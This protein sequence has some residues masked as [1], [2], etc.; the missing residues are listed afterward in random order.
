MIAFGYLVSVVVV[1]IGV[2]FYTL[3]LNSVS[4]ATSF[5]LAIIN[6]IVFSALGIRDAIKDKEPRS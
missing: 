2:V 1:F 6:V 4:L 3:T 5:T